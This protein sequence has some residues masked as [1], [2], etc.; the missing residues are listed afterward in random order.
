ME[1]WKQNQVQN[2]TLRMIKGMI[3]TSGK[4]SILFASMETNL[5]SLSY[6]FTRAKKGVSCPGES[7]SAALQNR[8]Q[9]T[10]QQCMR[11]NDDIWQNYT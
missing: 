5:G 2:E 11:Q 9:P 4:Q 3:E 8:I 1:K 10:G 7:L 6:P